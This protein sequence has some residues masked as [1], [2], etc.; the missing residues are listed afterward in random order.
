MDSVTAAP[1]DLSGVHH[2]SNVIQAEFIIKDHL[3]LERLPK[4][5]RFQI[6]DILI[7]SIGEVKL[8]SIYC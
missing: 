6:F 8:V 1:E 2:G 3:E 5:I 4:E 7:Q